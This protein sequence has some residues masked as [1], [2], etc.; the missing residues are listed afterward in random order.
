MRAFHPISSRR[1]RIAY[2]TIRPIDESNRHDHGKFIIPCSKSIRIFNGLHRQF[3]DYSRTTCLATTRD[4]QF[5]RTMISSWRVWPV[6][7]LRLTNCVWL[8]TPTT[9]PETTS[10]SSKR[11]MHNSI[12]GLTTLECF[13]IVRGRWNSN[14]DSASTKLSGTIMKARRFQEGYFNSGLVCVIRW[15]ILDVSDAL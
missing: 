12:D 6:S 15:I 5:A 4:A 11:G 14:I 3:C 1:F 7:S 13:D 8:Y 9:S 2:R 10:S